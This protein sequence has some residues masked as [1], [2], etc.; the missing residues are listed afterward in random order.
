VLNPPI[1]LRRTFTLIARS[2]VIWGYLFAV[3]I[4]GSA[5]S[6]THLYRTAAERRALAATYGSDNAVAALFGPAHNL[7]EV[8]G[9]TVFKVSMALSILGALWGLLTSTRALRGEEERG[10]WDSLA[11]GAVTRGGATAAALGGLAFGAIALW[12]VTAIATVLLAQDSAIAITPWAALYLALAEVASAWIFLALGALSSQ[13]L[14]T[15]RS[16]AGA[17]ATLLGISYA[18]R[19]LAD[20]G[21]GLH[22]LIWCSP[23][24]WVEELQ[25]LT[26]PQPLALIP[27]ALLVIIVGGATVVLAQLRDVG[28][29][30]LGDVSPRRTHRDGVRTP[31]ALS[32]R[33]LRAN[34]IGWSIA[35]GLSA[36]LY[37]AIARSAGSTITGGSIT[38]L[39]GRLGATGAGT[40]AVLGLC[41]LIIAVLLAFAALGQLRALTEEELEGRLTPLLVRPFARQRWLAERALI[42]LATLSLLGLGAGIL[43]WFGAASQHAGI[44]PAS[45]VLAGCNLVP[46][47]IVV[48]GVGLATFALLPRKVVTVAA[49]VIGWSLLIEVVGGIGAVNHWLLDSSLFHQMAAAPAVAP[50]LVSDLVRVGIGAIGAA[51]GLWGFRRR[52]LESE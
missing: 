38:Q 9:F 36:V 28:G 32:L 22:W 8:T 1:I 21:I 52:D 46:P 3:T 18:L 16:A 49:T 13:L 20:A 30:Y 34:L 26:N 10:R 45:L 40:R 19:L 37:G 41:F 2:S 42:A 27:I 5:L 11:V 39:L 12:G 29:A 44:D 7:G 15:R 51:I 33:L 47:A 50:H 23:L 48:L 24:G 25:P 43:A 17:A 31:L 4:V 14:P 6:Y 35:V